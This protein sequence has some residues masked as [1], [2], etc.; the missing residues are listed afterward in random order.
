MQALNVEFLALF[1][2]PFLATLMPHGVAHINALPCQV[3]ATFVLIAF[4]ALRTYHVIEVIDWRDDVSHVTTNDRHDSNRLC[5]YV[6]FLS[7]GL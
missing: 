1:S 2:M 7:F 4:I 6:F 5:V 3:E